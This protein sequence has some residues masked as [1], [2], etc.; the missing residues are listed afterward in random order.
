MDINNTSTGKVR[1]PLLPFILIDFLKKR[2]RKKEKKKITLE[3]D[4]YN[5][6][7]SSSPLNP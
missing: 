4:Q 7:S 5:T 1:K 3:G 6:Y 2:E